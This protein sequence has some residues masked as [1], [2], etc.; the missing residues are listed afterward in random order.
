MTNSATR[1]PRQTTMVPVTTMEEIPV[2]TDEEREALLRS[3]K[4]AEAQIAAG[5][6]IKYDPKTFKERLLAIYRDGKR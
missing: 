5:N 4:E 3:L 1:K 6:F 2:L